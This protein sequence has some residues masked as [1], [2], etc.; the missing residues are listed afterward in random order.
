MIKIHVIIIYLW[1]KWRFKLKFDA[2]KLVF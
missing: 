2:A 1:F